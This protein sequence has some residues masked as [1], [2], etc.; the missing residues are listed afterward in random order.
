MGHVISGPVWLGFF[1]H[2]ILHCQGFSNV[3][4]LLSPGTKKPFLAFKML[5]VPEHSECCIAPEHFLIPHLENFEFSDIRFPK[6]F[7]C[8]FAEIP[9]RSFACPEFSALSFCLSLAIQK[10]SVL[11]LEFTD[12]TCVELSF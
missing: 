4:Q 9:N 11:L 7:A 12:F 5:G 6:F 10:F 8:S 1:F 3:H 2:W